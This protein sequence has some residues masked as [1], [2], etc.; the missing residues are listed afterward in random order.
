MQGPKC[1]TQKRLN[2]VYEVQRE[3]FIRMMCGDWNERSCNEY[4]KGA[5]E[6]SL[7]MRYQMILKHFTLALAL[8]S[9]MP[10]NY[11]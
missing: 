1:L 7:G 11:W 2:R 9:A 6:L 3:D 5:P 10:L 8:G 4:G